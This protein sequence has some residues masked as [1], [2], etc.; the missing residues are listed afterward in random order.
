MASL[1]HAKLNNANLSGANLEL[2]QAAG[3]EFRQANLSGAVL[4]MAKL[5]GADFTLSNLMGAD[6]NE[7]DLSGANLILARIDVGT[8]LSGITLDDQTRLGGI[9]WNGTSLAVL[10]WTQI[11]IFGDEVDI[12]MAN[13]RDELESAHAD[14]ADAYRG[15]SIALRGQGLLDA[16]AEYR[17]RQERLERKALF[18]RRKYGAALISGLLDLLAG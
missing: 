15:I 7:A 3:A 6:F 8:L 12:K 4:Q 9:S 5:Q 18:L 16:A 13:D 2:I 11:P 1:R 10:D 17:L 14:A